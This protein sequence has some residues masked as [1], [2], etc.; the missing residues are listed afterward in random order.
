[1]LSTHRRWR[2]R[3]R[4]ALPIGFLLAGQ[5]DSSVGL[6]LERER[7]ITLQPETT[8]H[9]RVIAVRSPMSEDTITWKGP[10]A[11]GAD[12]TFTTQGPQSAGQGI[13]TGSETGSGDGQ[14]RLPKQ[15]GIHGLWGQR[16]AETLLAKAADTCSE[17]RESAEAVQELPQEVKADK[18]RKGRKEALRPPKAKSKRKK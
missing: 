6:D 8:Y 5:A 13:L 2:G 12:Q 18:L 4:G 16:P 3:A 14:R 10:P 7:G 1:M 9:Y 17:A 11:Y 15:R